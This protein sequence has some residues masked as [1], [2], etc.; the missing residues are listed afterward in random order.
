MEGYGP[1]RIADLLQC[2]ELDVQTTLLSARIR[3]RNTLQQLR[4]RAQMAPAVEQVLADV[5]DCA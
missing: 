5:A 4:A 3:M 2:T 1:G